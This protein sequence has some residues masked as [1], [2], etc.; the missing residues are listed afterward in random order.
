MCLR[1]RCVPEY[2]RVEAAVT[3][4]SAVTFHFGRRGCARLY[5]SSGRVRL[6]AFHF[7]FQ[8]HFGKEYIV[9]LTN[10]IRHIDNLQ[11]KADCAA[12]PDS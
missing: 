7:F 3:R 11:L 9:T 5:V 2:A 8:F 12:R 6:R 1:F 10:Y 4:L